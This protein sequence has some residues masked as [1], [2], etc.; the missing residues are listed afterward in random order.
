[1]SQTAGI[2][3]P[4]TSGAVVLARAAADVRSFVRERRAAWAAI[5]GWWAISRA[6]V[7]ATALVVQYVRWPRASWYPSISDQPLALLGAWDGRWY[8]L[9]ATRGYLEISDHQS[10]IAFFPFF[11]SLLRV[12]RLL[13]LPLNVTGILV[14][15]ACFLVAVLALFEL[16]RLWLDE[17]SARRASIYV[18]IF[19]AGYVFSMVYP[20]SLV[21]AAIAFAGV[22]A[23][24]G[25]W[26][27]AALAAAVA[28]IT[29]PEA[30]L[31]VLPLGALAARA[32]PKSDARTR[33]AALTA[34]AAAPAALA[35]L[36]AYHWA[37]FG[38][39]LAFSS[40]QR[41]W[42][43]S[44]SFDG[45]ERAVVQLVQSPGSGNAWLF[46]DAAFFVLYLVVLVVALRAGVPRSWVLA[47]TLIVVLPVWSGSFTSDARF[48]LLA[49]P[50]Y[51]G[52]AC[53]TRRR[54][55][56]V[57]LRILSLVLLGAATA[58]ILL[59]WP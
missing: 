6:T 44:L 57:G 19:P 33:C 34:A 51:A 14:A 56:D 20:E 5:V 18:A 42:G 29:R 35:G 48:G 31:L 41:A 10:D 15:N 21:L 22:L 50:V 27:W 32:W 24:R 12:G 4:A 38:D 30:L 8:R 13:G 45:M 9:I 28:A 2:P 46:R 26:T 47:S 1:V 39:P 58:T 3:Q 43:R 52:L 40:A 16:N 55:V 59:R 17:A 25:R 23:V 54:P 7:L 37:T 53:L 36:A 11:P 49:P